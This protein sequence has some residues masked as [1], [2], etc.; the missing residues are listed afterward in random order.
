MGSLTIAI[1]SYFFRMFIN[2]NVWTT[3]WVMWNPTDVQV[4]TGVLR[5]QS[6]YP[7]W[8]SLVLQVMGVK[9]SPFI[10][11]LQIPSLPS[12]V[13]WKH[14]WLGIQSPYSPEW[15][16]SPLLCWQSSF[17]CQSIP[18]STPCHANQ[19][20]IQHKKLS[21]MTPTTES[22][23]RVHPMLKRIRGC[24]FHRYVCAHVCVYGC[25]CVCAWEALLVISVPVF[26]SKDMG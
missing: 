10:Y 25:V 13:H 5:A 8:L 21:V 20:G 22:S 16:L 26:L 11:S 24:L 19:L 1:D 23:G 4:D 14:L 3:I 2:G 15:T 18:N 6:P 17:L 9:D 12:E 7:L